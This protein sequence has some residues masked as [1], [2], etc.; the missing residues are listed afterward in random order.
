MVLLSQW[1]DEVIRIH[2]EQLHFGESEVCL[3]YIGDI[4]EQIIEV[5]KER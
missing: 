5:V 3:A 2:S 1:S 4:K